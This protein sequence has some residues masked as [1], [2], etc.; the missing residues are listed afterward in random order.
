MPKKLQK[1]RW[2]TLIELPPKS[3]ENGY[4]LSVALP[5]NTKRYVRLVQRKGRFFLQ[6][7]DTL[8]PTAQDFM[9]LH[10]PNLTILTE[11]TEK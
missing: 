7:R 1:D 6:H 4:K 3:V 5:P 9:V 10:T 11:P 8:P 2:R